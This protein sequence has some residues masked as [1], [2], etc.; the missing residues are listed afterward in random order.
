MPFGRG[1]G[2][3]Y[4]L[5][6]LPIEQHQR[7]LANLRVISLPLG[8]VIYESGERQSRL[9][10]PTTAV[11]SLLYT[12]KDG[13]TAEAGLTGN[14]G[15]IGLALFLGGTAT[16]DRAVVQIGG[17]ALEMSPEL[18]HEELAHGG[19]FQRALLRYTRAFIIQIS[20]TAVCNRLHSINKRLC[21]WLL[22]CH[23]RV[24]TDDLAMT[25]EFI[26]NMLGVRRESVTMAAAHLQNAGLIRYARGHI[27]IVDRHGLEAAA[28]ECYQFVK[29]ESERLL[30]P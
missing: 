25:Q 28:C 11:V 9:Y 21:R 5:S 19:A 6:A 24:Q 14:D 15:V 3:N 12:M 26:A 18:L 17:S 20:Q 1:S 2:E 13:S 16:P 27:K 7:L 8:K 22:L 30:D 29:Q 10:F 23:D 4:L